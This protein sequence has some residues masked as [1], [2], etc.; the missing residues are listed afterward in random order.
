MDASA[1][2]EYFA[3]LRAWLAE[4]NAGRTCGWSAPTALAGAD[5]PSIGSADDKR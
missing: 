2:L 4:E 3:P 1:M 5:D